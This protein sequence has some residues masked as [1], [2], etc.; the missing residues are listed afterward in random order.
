M[1]LTR[2]PALVQRSNVARGT[3]QASELAGAVHRYDQR[4]TVEAAV[5]TCL[6]HLVAELGQVRQMRDD[7]RGPI[8]MP[9]ASCEPARA[10]ADWPHIDALCGRA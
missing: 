4:R 6:H 2:P 8:R 5:A 10:R 3:R 1:H 9:C 7:L